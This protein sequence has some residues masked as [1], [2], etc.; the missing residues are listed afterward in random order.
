MPSHSLL[1]HDHPKWLPESPPPT[2]SLKSSPLL[3]FSI[4]M[5][6]STDQDGQKAPMSQAKC[7]F[8]TGHDYTYSPDL[9]QQVNLWVDARWL[10]RTGCS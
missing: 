7:L 3:P 8:M 5:A 10:S 6:I 2:V 9:S 1:C 4:K